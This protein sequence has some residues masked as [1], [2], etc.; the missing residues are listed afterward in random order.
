MLTRWIAFSGLL[1]LLNCTHTVGA[2]APQAPESDP[3]GQV[4][5]VSLIRGDLEWKPAGTSSWRHADLNQPLSVGDEIWTANDGRAELQTGAATIRLAAGT[6]MAFLNLSDEVIQIKLTLGTLRV[7]LRSLEEKDAFEL[8]TPNAAI[9]LLRAGD[10]RLEV[11]PV[12]SSARLAVYLGNAE[13][14][15]LKQTSV[16]HAGEEL[17]LT[18]VETLTTATGPLRAED[19]F[20]AFCISRDREAERSRSAEYVS[21]RVIGYSDLDAYGSWSVDVTWGPVWM[22]SRVPPLWA[23]YRFGHWIWMPPWGWTWVDDTPW[24]FAPFHYGRWLRLRGNWSWLPGPRIHR[25]IYAPALVV[26]VG[27]GSP[28]LQYHY[29]LASG[30]GVAWFPLGPREIYTPPFR[31]SRRYVT[32]VNISNTVVIHPDRIH[33]SDP[34]RQNYRNRHENGAVTAVP[35][36]DFVG[37]RPLRGVAQVPSP[38]DVSRTQIS[39]MAPPVDPRREPLVRGGAAG[40]VVNGPPARNS[41]PAIVRQPTPT[42]DPS[43]RQIPRSPGERGA[44]RPEG[45]PE[46]PTRQP[47][48]PADGRQETRTPTRTERERSRSIERERSPSSRVPAERRRPE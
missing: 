28:R 8:S 14:H 7:R 35:R 38:A 45:R 34:Y 11:Q 1:C 44:G 18:G 39:G 9:S 4:A 40:G 37:G 43:V 33:Q 22:P 31:A 26:F 32:N 20:D 41:P 46:A 17:T 30:L 10:Y 3:P 23:P 12:S 27:G 2:R 21:P 19:D 36:E 29:Q 15:G 6:Q 48:I 13:V 25:A 24:G 42:R 5:R 16:A 47:R